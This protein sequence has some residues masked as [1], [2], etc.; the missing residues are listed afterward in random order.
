MVFLKQIKIKHFLTPTTRK[1][2]LKKLKLLSLN[3][4]CNYTKR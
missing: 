2:S 1:K 4:K 3:F